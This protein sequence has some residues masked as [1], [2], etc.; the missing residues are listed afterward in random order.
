[1][2][3]TER[4]VE[5]I[6]EQMAQW[7]QSL[8]EFSSA[9]SKLIEQNQLLNSR[10]QQLQSEVQQLKTSHILEITFSANLLFWT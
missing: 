2:T 1:M 7:E 3:S 8:N 4:K 9:I 5:L 10:M 6:F